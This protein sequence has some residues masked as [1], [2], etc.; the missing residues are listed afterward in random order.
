MP[1]GHKETI[2]K[3]KF[4]WS[5]DDTGVLTAIRRKKRSW[6]ARAADTIK[7]IVHSIGDAFEDNLFTAI[8]QV[9][10][11]ALGALA[12]VF[13][14][15]Q[16]L[17]I[18]SL[19]LSVGDAVLKAGQGDWLGALSAGLAVFTAGAADVFS[20][21]VPSAVDILQQGVVNELFQGFGDPTVLAFLKDAKRVVDIGSAV[22]HALDANGLVAAIGATIGA[23][24]VALGSGG[25]LLQDPNCSARTWPT[26]WSGWA[27]PSA[28]SMAWSYPAPGWLPHWRPATRAR[29]WPTV[30]P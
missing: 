26:A 17:G 3:Y 19:A 1:G 10:K 15:T 21:G 24:A 7:A 27:A 20:L 30:C 2:G 28:T 11:I 25:Q 14:G 13:P 8:V 16:A 22:V 5:F 29:L 18:A 9:G 23:G 12:L 6:F 4:T